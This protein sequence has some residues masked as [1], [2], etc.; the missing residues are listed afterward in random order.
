MLKVNLL[1]MKRIYFTK[2]IPIFQLNLKVIL[3]N[4]EVLLF[5]DSHSI[6]TNDGRVICMSGKKNTDNLIVL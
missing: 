1:K 6:L 3:V 4:A 2:Q 5:N